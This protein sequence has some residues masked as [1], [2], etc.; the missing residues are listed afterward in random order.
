MKILVVDDEPS[1][2]KLVQRSLGE[3][4]Y[5]VSVAVNGLEG[6]M[7]A[8]E[9]APDVIIADVLMP[10]MD[11]YELV[12]TVRR[13]PSTS[14]IPVILLSGRRGSDAAVE[15]YRCGADDYVSKPV[16]VEVLRHK[17]D[18]LLRRAQAGTGVPLP[19]LGHLTC[20]TSAKGGTGVTTLTAN[21][22][23]LLCRRSH[24]VC[25]A[26]LDLEHGDLQVHLDLRPRA[27][28][29][30]ASRDV[31]AITEGAVQWD[32][33]LERHATGAWLLAAPATPHEASSLA[34]PVVNQVVAALRSVHDHV[35]VDVPPSY[36][37]LALSMYER[38]ERVLVV[39]SAELTAMRRTRE[40]LTILEG[41][42]VTGDRVVVVLNQIAEKGGIDREKVEAFLRRPVNVVIPFGG[43]AFP[44]AVNGGRPVATTQKGK[45][46]DAMAEIAGLL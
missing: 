46:V 21:L 17:I 36:G 1:V 35:L 23:V 12:R 29:A 9:S 42:G 37:E 34:E 26:D 41:L 40:L 18:A 27:G 24:T 14:G 32:D 2:R 38:A 15:G 6:W 39:T 16:D 10:E 7:A 31:H 19:A 8:R 33:Y 11:G 44:E 30:E 28:I 22:A 45:A 20:V 4:G 43:R 25:V 3:H 5:D 13:N